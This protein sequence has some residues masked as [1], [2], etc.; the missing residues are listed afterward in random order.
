VPDADGDFHYRMK[1][2]RGQGRRLINSKNNTKKQ[3]RVSHLRADLHCQGYAEKCKAR[4]PWIPSTDY[5]A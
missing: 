4:L 1:L 3:K 5:S 2:D